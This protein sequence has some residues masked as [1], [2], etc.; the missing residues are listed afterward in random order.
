MEGATILGYIAGTCTTIAFLPQVL[1][2]YRTKSCHDLSSGML[3]LFSLGIFFWFVYGLLIDE[4]PIIA[5]NG[6][7]LVFVLAIVV[8]KGVYGRSEKSPG[9]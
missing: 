6:L 7:T 5:A 1:K 3:A 2:A 9:D 4:M 8:L